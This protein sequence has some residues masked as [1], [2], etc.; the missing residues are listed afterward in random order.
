MRCVHLGG[1][2]SGQ[3]SFLF[4]NRFPVAFLMLLQANFFLCS[5]IR[6]LQ[7]KKKKREK[8]CKI[9]GERGGGEWNELWRK[10]GTVYLG[11]LRASVIRQS[12]R[13][14]SEAEFTHV[15]HNIQI[16][17][18]GSTKPHTYYRILIPYPGNI[19]SFTNLKWMHTCIWSQY[20][21]LLCIV[22]AP[23]NPSHLWIFISNW[24]SW[25]VYHVSLISEA[26]RPPGRVA[27]LNTCLNCAVWV[28]LVSIY[29]IYRC[30]K[31][32]SLKRMS[33]KGCQEDA[34]SFHRRDNGAYFNNTVAL[35]QCYGSPVCH[36]DG[37]DA[38]G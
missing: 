17:V 35:G 14:G 12:W 2:E 4:T 21:W 7:V 8:V 38:T 13:N 1:G 19:T 28:S 9:V 18:C 11:A 3:T 34:V 25:I 15:G 24:I 26:T 29:N 33:E 16:G 23:N 22:S 36:S 31:P 5:V 27:A 6:L 20:Y 10:W 37:C 30:S 32:A